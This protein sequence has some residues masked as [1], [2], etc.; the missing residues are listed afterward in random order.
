M[1][2]LLDQFS[3]EGA[4][5]IERARASAKKYRHSH[6]SPEHLL[7]G[8]VEAGGDTALKIIKRGR[9]TPAQIAELVRHHLREGEYDIPADQLGF[10]ERGKRV[11]DAA[12]QE[13][14]RLQAPKVEPRHILLGLSKVPNT[15]AAAVLG[16]VDLKGEDAFS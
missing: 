14:A 1:S 16:A 6:I 8:I 13:C 11:L 3:P 15:V 10:S 2:T 9:A 7:L 4:A 5:V 12:R